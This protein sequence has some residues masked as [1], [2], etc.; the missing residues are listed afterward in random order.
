MEVE[1]TP[2]QELDGGDTDFTTGWEGKTE[3]DDVDMRSIEETVLVEAEERARKNNCLMCFK[4]TSLTLKALNLKKR[5]LLLLQRDKLAL[6][7]LKELVGLPEEKL[8]EYYLCRREMGKPRT[9]LAFCADCVAVA[10]VAL[11]L[12]L[13]MEE[14]SNKLVAVKEQFTNVIKKS[15]ENRQGEVNLPSSKT[16]PSSRITREARN[17]VATGN[18]ILV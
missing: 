9:W 17:Y 2:D 8:E 1:E 15:F 14:L 16:K 6:L 12:Q 18:E 5:E 7:I 11:K 3:E 13:E 4:T 10:S